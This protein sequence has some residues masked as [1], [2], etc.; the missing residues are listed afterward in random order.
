MTL[1]DVTFT[2]YTTRPTAPQRPVVPPGRPPGAA[3]AAAGLLPGRLGAA[4]GS[5]RG[6]CRRCSRP[7][8]RPRRAACGG[9]AGRLPGGGG[10]REGPAVPAAGLRVR[11]GACWPAGRAVPAYCMFAGILNGGGY[12]FDV[13]WRMAPSEPPFRPHRPCRLPEPIDQA[14]PAR[15]HFKQLLA[16]CDDMTPVGPPQPHRPLHCPPYALSPRSLSL[17]TLTRFPRAFRV[18]S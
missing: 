8:P 10:R 1:T 17:L 7:S 5:T 9:P 4:G 15:R 13:L 16:P 3:A 18:P 12:G 14:V 6:T 11:A 2:F